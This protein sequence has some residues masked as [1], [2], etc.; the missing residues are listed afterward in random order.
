M[1]YTSVII[2]L[3]TCSIAIMSDY[4]EGEPKRFQMLLYW[5]KK[6]IVDFRTR[7]EHIYVQK[8][9]DAR[10]YYSN[11]INSLQD[12]DVRNSKVKY[13]MDL[14]DKKLEDIEAWK[15]KKLNYEFYL[16]PIILCVYCMPSFWGSIIYV[17]LNGFTNP[18]EWVIS[19]TMSVFINAFIWDLY[20]KL[21]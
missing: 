1:I 11:A 21:N 10:E 6:P 20:T 5:L 8:Q 14:Q 17:S 7:I 12:N 9:K 16:K 19:C 3:V 18:V 15:E 13:Y 2:S 4:K